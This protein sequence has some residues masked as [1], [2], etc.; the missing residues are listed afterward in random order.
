M[1]FESLTMHEPTGEVLTTIK[2]DLEFSV[3]NNGITSISLNDLS[4]ILLID[5]VNIDTVNLYPVTINSQSSYEFS[6]TFES[7]NEEAID[8]YGL[9]EIQVHL[10]LKSNTGSLWYSSS[11]IIEDTETRQRK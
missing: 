7:F 1:M 2:F 10:V 5:E 8:L 6:E 3:R 4:I 9:E 11:I